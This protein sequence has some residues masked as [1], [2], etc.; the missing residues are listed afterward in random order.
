MQRLSITEQLE[1]KF[2]VPQNIVIQGASSDSR[3]E[4]TITEDLRVKIVRNNQLNECEPS[5]RH[6]IFH[7]RHS[8]EDFLYFFGKS[9]YIDYTKRYNLDVFGAFSVLYGV[10][11]TEGGDALLLDIEIT[12][13]R[14]CLG[15]SDVTKFLKYAVDDNYVGLARKLTVFDTG[16]FPV[17]CGVRVYLTSETNALRLTGNPYVYIEYWANYHKKFS[18]HFTPIADSTFASKE[19]LPFPLQTIAEVDEDVPMEFVHVNIP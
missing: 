7:P 10:N 14:E 2:R 13:P 4:Y 9:K 5:D 17:F 6:P 15:Y 12:F 8:I 19:S 11:H 18:K 3:F 1:A 16:D